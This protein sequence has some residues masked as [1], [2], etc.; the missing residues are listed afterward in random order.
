MP[1]KLF[2]YPSR[3][4]H[5]CLESI[6]V[7]NGARYLEEY[8]L[9]QF[10]F[11]QNS[12]A[13]ESRDPTTGMTPLLIATRSH[14]M[15]GKQVEFINFLLA[16]GADVNARDHNGLTPLHHIAYS[17]PPYSYFDKVVK[18]LIENGADTDAVD[19]KGNTFVHYAATNMSP[20]K[21]HAL[22][23]YLISM[24][25]TKVLKIATTGPLSILR[26]FQ[27]Q[28]RMLCETMEL[29]HSVC[30]DFSDDPD[31]DYSLFD[32]S[33][34]LDWKENH[35]KTLLKCG[36]QIGM[37]YHNPKQRSSLHLAARRG[38]VDALKVLLAIGIDVN[39]QDFYGDTP[40]HC[41]I[42]HNNREAIEFLVLKNAN[43]NLRNQCGDT[44]IDC[45]ITKQFSS[46]KNENVIYGFPTWA[47]QV[48]RKYKAREGSTKCKQRAAENLK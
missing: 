5:R 12:D 47:G 17:V 41:A 38:N 45:A 32:L 14:F 1:S 21:F 11:K 22:V 44:P 10:I 33:I 16:Y 13:I 19:G 27:S 7:I 15:N 35:L 3:Y 6:S 31:T 29:I 8:S 46:A 18:L 40:L 48:V 37:E 34:I 4:V 2:Q 43:V 9:L 36:A 24:G 25:R 30:G 28:V 42:E 20:N 39:T 23:P 26:T